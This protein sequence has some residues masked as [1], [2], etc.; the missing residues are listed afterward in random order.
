MLVL[1]IILLPTT[2]V[3]ASSYVA[4]NDIIIDTKY[5]D[6]FNSQ[7]GDEKSLS[8]PLLIFKDTPF[9]TV[10]FLKDFFRSF[11]SNKLMGRLLIRCGSRMGY[12]TGSPCR[13]GSPARRPQCGHR[14]R[15]GNRA[16]A[17]R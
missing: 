14:S 12:G 4:K 13:T 16:Q 7:F 6:F 1:A 8:T 5:Y 10:L 2:K 11:T 3:N 9:T 17:P 15:R